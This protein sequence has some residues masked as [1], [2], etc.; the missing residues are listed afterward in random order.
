MEFLQSAPAETTS[1]MIAGYAVIF[2]VIFLY[3][4]S[5]FVRQRNLEADFDLLEEMGGQEG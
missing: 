1:Y 4:V 5:L 2:G 3:V